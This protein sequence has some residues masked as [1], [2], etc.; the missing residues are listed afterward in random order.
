MRKI[1]ILGLLAVILVTAGIVTSAYACP[2]G[3]VPCGNACC[4]R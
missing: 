4:P 1:R 2:A 3:Y